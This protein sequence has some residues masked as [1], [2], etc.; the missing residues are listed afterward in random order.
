MSNRGKGKV[1]ASTLK[2]GVIQTSDGDGEDSTP[3]TAPTPSHEKPGTKMK[4]V[5]R[6]DGKSRR[7]LQ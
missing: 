6:A 2:L 7:T 5:R 1:S 3:D 4:H